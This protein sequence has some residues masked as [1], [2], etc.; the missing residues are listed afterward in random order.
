MSPSGSESAPPTCLVGH[1]LGGR[2]A[3][4]SAG[5]PEVVSAVALAPW[6]YPTDVPAELHGA[7][8][9]IVHG[10]D[11]RIADPDRSEALARRIAARPGGAEVAYVT[12]RR[13]THSMLARHAVFDGL[14]AGFAA[15]TLLG[16]AP[17]GVL[18][19]VAAGATRLEV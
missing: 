17:E 7:R 8:I 5:R 4:L 12:V 14:A 16:E 18:A 11:D 15:V 10:A 9:L 6:V 1:S 19:R 2:A 13:G 3:L